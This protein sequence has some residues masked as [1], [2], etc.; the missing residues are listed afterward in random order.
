MRSLVIAPAQMQAD[1]FG[2]NIA[3]RMVE[4]LDMQL[5]DLAKLGRA[6]AGELDVAAHREVRAIDLQQEARAMDSVV[7]DLHRVGERGDIRLVG[8]VVRVA[9]ELR[10]HAR[11]RRAQK[12]LARTDAGERG[13]EIVEVALEL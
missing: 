7:L 11:R 6:G 12:S 9:E 4:R 13:L 2:R 10:D 3:Q 1:A 8:R 5:G